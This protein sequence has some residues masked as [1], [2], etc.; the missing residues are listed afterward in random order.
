MRRRRLGRGGIE[1]SAIGLGCWGMSGSYG[2]ADEAES[3]ATLLHALDLG[4]NLI[5][6]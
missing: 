4:V 5:D 3:G 2:P 6:T 1:V